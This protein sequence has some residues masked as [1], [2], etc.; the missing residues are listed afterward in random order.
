[1][2]N[3]TYTVND[4]LK[5]RNAGPLGTD[6][7]SLERVNDFLKEAYQIVCAAPFMELLLTILTA[8]R[9]SA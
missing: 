8:C 7:Y 5:R 6:S 9:I 4:L 3:L 2:S 1:M